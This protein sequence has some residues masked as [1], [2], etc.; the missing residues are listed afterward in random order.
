MKIPMKAVVF[1][2]SA[3]LAMSRTVR[4]GVTKQQKEIS[5]IA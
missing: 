2:E 5:M 3:G 4:P 1:V